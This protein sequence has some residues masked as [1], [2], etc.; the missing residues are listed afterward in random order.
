[1]FTHYQTRNKC[2]QKSDTLLLSR[3]LKQCMTFQR[4]RGS[5]KTCTVP[6][7]EQHPEVP[8]RFPATVGTGVATTG[9]P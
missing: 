7:Q 9:N 5:Q 4:V 8:S 1:M 2:I 6:P 3:L